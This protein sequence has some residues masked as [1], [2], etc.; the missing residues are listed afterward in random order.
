MGRRDAFGRST[1]DLINGRIE[2]AL[3][4]VEIYRSNVRKAF[5]L[6]SPKPPPRQLVDFFWCRQRRLYLLEEDVQFSNLPVFSFEL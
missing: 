2:V 4:E 6:F 3:E 5:L 1:K